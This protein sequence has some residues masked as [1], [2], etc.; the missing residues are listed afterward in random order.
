MPNPVYIGAV[1]KADLGGNGGG[2]IKARVAV[3]VS[4]RQ[5]GEAIRQV[6][7]NLGKNPN[8][9][10]RRTG[11]GNNNQPQ[12][13]NAGNGNNN[14]PVLKNGNQ[15]VAPPLRDL[16][17]TGN[18][19]QQ[20]A[21]DNRNDTAVNNRL[22]Q[23]NN[24]TNHASQKGLENGR[25]H[26]KTT[27]QNQ[28]QTNTT[29][30]APPNNQ[31]NVNPQ[32]NQTAQNNPPIN[33]GQNNQPNNQNT[34][35][36]PLADTVR[37]VVGL[38]L[39]RNDVFINAGT[40]NK[41]FNQNF[42]TGGQMQTGNSHELNHLIQ[43]IGSRILSLLDNSQQVN[44]RII[45]QIATEVSLQFQQ[46]IETARTSLLQNA[47]LGAKTFKNLNINERMMLAVEFLK[48]HLPP[49]DVAESLRSF[50]PKEIL[51]GLFLVRG[52]VIAQENTADVRNLVAFQSRVLPDE[53][54]LTA[55]RDVGLLV[56]ILI[57]DAI[58][59]K[60][61]ANLDQ[62]V[63]KFI[64]FLLA[65]NELG[66]LLAS[67]SLAAQTRYSGGL[68]SRSLALAQIYDLINR[69]I[70]AG[71]KALKD[72]VLAQKAAKNFGQTAKSDILSFG[73]SNASEKDEPL[74]QSA[75]LQGAESA[76]RQFLE[77]NPAFVFDNSAS[78]FNNSDDA[79]EAQNSFVSL[80][81]DDIDCWLKSGNHRFVKDF[82]L[83]KPVGVVIERSRDGIFMSGTI[84]I[85]LVRDGSVQGWHFLKSFLIK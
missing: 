62:A 46:Q 67:V 30:N 61:A 33:N 26:H 72:A 73:I 19:D 77:F 75:K 38:V 5:S 14:P 6:N 56:K 43:N 2:K 69:L 60:S 35:N 45:R 1:G 82:E 40:V 27:P 44:G 78:A 80:Y 16:R 39:G 84:R 85:V 42:Q 41:F 53:I 71:E 10:P 54:S 36:Q 74:L 59:A 25:G 32:N 18:P 24:G 66:V 20:P 29:N 58:G 7:Q 22:R 9:A 68:I 48:L 11:Q 17:T 76:L 23:G 64:R 52:L 37:Q 57:S 3:K 21:A 13:N 47:D 83:E 81:Q 70:I 65:N 34:N 55:L 15:T 49:T 31:G 63:Q 12:V 8:H 50:Q 79:R 51:S 4:T 28:N